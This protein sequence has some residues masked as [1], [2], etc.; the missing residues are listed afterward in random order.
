MNASRTA[1]R[2]EVTLGGKGVTSRAGLVV[3]AELADR[4]GL[5]RAMYPASFPTRNCVRWV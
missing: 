1:N 2:V 4:L 5:T 3:V